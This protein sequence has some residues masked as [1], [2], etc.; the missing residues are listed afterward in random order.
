M[1]NLNSLELNLV[2]GGEKFLVMTT[3]IDMIG[4]P[5]SCIERFF[6]NATNLTLM[7]ITDEMLHST[8]TANCTEYWSSNKH[9]VSYEANTIYMN[10]TEE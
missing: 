2:S 4:L 9:N 8:L 1:K 5:A 7:G 6:N 10:I 3:T